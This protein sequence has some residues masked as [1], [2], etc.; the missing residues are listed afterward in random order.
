M[1]DVEAMIEEIEE[2]KPN[3]QYEKKERFSSNEFSLV[4]SP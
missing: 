4:L 1:E 2:K 3:G